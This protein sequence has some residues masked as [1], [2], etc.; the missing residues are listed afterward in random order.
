MDIKYLQYLETLRAYIANEEPKN[1]AEEKKDKEWQ[2]EFPR[3]IDVTDCNLP[4][5]IDWDRIKNLCIRYMKKLDNDNPPS[6]E[7]CR[8]MAHWLVRIQDRGSV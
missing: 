3:V 8:E 5:D 2:K 1:L 4:D 7:L 6:Y